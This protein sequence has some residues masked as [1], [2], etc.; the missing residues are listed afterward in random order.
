MRKIKRIICI[1]LSLALLFL[2]ACSESADETEQE[3]SATV[4]YSTPAASVKKSETVYVNL[5]NTGAK[6]SIKVS[7]WLHVPQ[8][9]VYVDDVTNLTSIVNVKDDSKPEVSG[10]KLRWH[11]ST[12]DLYYQGDYNGNLPLEFDITYTL[13]GQPISAKEI[14]GKS[15]KAAITVKMKNVDASTVRVNGVNMTMYNPM[16]VVGGISLNETKFQNIN[17]ENGRIVG[18][19]N[20]QYAVLAGFPGINESLGLSKIQ[21]N[22]SSDYTFND[23]FVI[24]A[25]VTNFEIGN[26]MFSAIPI[27][28]LDIGLNDISST[29]DSLRSNLQKLQNVQKSLQQI[30]ASNLLNT[31]SS[32]PDKLNN[33]SSLVEQ[34][35]SLYDQNKA[36]IN[37]LN[38]YTTSENLAAIQVLVEYIRTADFDGLEDALK[39]INSIFGDDANQETINKGLELLRQMSSDLNDPEVQKAIEN[40]PKTVNT[41]SELQKAVEENKDLINVLKSLSETNALSSI[42]STLSSLKGSIAT[43]SLSSLS[44]VD[45]NELSAKMTAW[46]ELGKAYTIFTKKTQTMTSSVMFVYKTDSVRVSSV[47]DDEDTEKIQAENEAEE[48]SGLKGLFQKI[49]K[50]NEG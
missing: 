25:D 39:V 47:N 1:L 50:K 26:F 49:F 11:L 36:L 46:L 28:S 15:G 3:D 4:K 27:A 48:S 6:K 23:T 41:L 34:A 22:G 2:C 40:L 37:V 38:K 20:N 33:L 9:G 5:D 13:N 31:L 7:D 10:Q 8:G 43:D 19:G 14:A 18:N 16:L 21:S 17:V 24:T 44:G 30:D 42:D 29:V 32:N 12:T 35:S 45:A